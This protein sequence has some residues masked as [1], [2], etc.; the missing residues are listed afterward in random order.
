MDDLISKRSATER[1]IIAK[2][3]LESIL[4]DM[5]TA[6]PEII[7]CRE[8]KHNYVDGDNVRFN[9]CELMHNKVQ[10]DD[11]Y[12]ADAERRTDG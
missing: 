9:V 8:C 10:S 12:C 7:R 1:M 6:E 4:T 11:W 3:L 5:P 2:T